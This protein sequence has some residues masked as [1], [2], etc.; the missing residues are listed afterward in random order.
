MKKVFLGIAAILVL[1]IG[2]MYINLNPGKG[3]LSPEISFLE[4]QPIVDG[5][6][7]ENLTDQ[8]S[9]RK[10]EFRFNLNLFKGSA[11]SNYRIAYGTNFI[12][13]FLEAKADSFICRD[14]G[15]QNGDGFILTISN[16]KPDS[17]KTDE[18]Y[19]MGFSSQYILDQKWAEKILWNYNGKVILE[20]LSDDV[21]FEYQAIDGKIGFELVIPWSELYPYHPFLSDEIGFNLWFMKAHQGRRLPNVQGVSFEF[22]SETGARRYKT[23]EFEQPQL[24]KNCQSYL[25]LEKNHCFQGEILKFKTAFISTRQLNE[26]FD[27]SLSNDSGEVVRSK[28]F[29]TDVHPGLSNHRFELDVSDL[30][31]GNYSI[32]W[33]GLESSSAGKLKLTILPDFRNESVIERLNSVKTIIPEGSYTTLLFHIQNITQK[34]QK[35]KDYEDVP[36]GL[37]DILRIFK[38]LEQIETGNDTISI[39]TGIFRRAFRSDLDNTIQPYKIQI[40]ENYNKSKNYP[41]LVFLHGS[42][43]TDEDM[44]DKSHQYLSQ[45]NFIQIAPNAR[46]VSHYYGN[47]KAQFDIREAI[48]DVIKNYSVD[49]SNIILAGFSMGGYGVYRTYI[50]SPNQFKGLAVFSGIPKAGRFRRSGKGEYPNFQKKKNYEKLIDIPI[51]IY[52]GKNDLNCPFEWTEKFVGKLNSSEANVKFVYNEGTGHSS[53][54][55]E[56]IL[57]QYYQWLNEL[58]VEK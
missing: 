29:N 45:G 5:L 2:Y 27:L 46:G 8:L 51:F 10:Y 30:N 48:H 6:L 23:V 12:Y 58:I 52:H 22:P 24:T 53:P 38:L 32:L 41:L 42:G 17:D 40:P 56:E 25:I 13:L 57:N 28:T 4:N 37:E 35:N 1:F 26:T 44:F 14:R 21:L 39:K 16:T 47:E 54:D 49:T 55:D 34:L 19:V 9:K 3:P 7:D 36:G 18:H 20:R 50:E 15:Y 31:P 33:S 11:G 43:R